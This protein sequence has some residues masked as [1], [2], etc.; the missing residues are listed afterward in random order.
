VL[1][2]TGLAPVRSDALET[3][4]RAGAVTVNF[5]TDDPWNPA[6]KA[7]W[8]FEALPHYDFV[9]TP[10]R[11]NIED[12]ARAGCR[13]VVYLP[14]GYDDAIFYPQP[15]ADE[16]E[17]AALASDV[18]F[19]GGADAERLP[20]I[21]ALV[22]SGLDIHLYGNNWEKHPRLG[23]CSRGIADPAMVRRGLSATRLGLCLV[24]RANRDG[25]SMRTFEVPATG[26]CAL[27]EDTAEHREIFHADGE[28]VSYFGSVGEM[29]EKA[30]WLVD[31]P[32]ERQSLAARCH[33]LI[34]AGG[35]TYRDRLRRILATARPS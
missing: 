7:G 4:R 9:F 8:F 24:R 2:T 23:R 32:Q 17:R 11:S 3:A 15:P 20:Y 28:N 6:H 29:V 25:N 31:H 22:A 26:A 10:R 16:A 27:V 35:H 19:A 21:E 34:T 1:L 14:F 33:R 5:L 18:F 30:R 13:R 12:L